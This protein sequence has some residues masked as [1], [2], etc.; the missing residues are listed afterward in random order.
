MKKGSKKKE[1]ADFFSS[2]TAY[3]DSIYTQNSGD[4][5]IFDHITVTGRQHYLLRFLLDHKV[6]GIA[7]DI[8]CG[9]GVLMK[10][11]EKQQVQTVGLDISPA[12]ARKTKEVM[13]DVP[14]FLGVVQGDIEHLPFKPRAFAAVTSIGVLQYLKDDKEAIA[15]MCRVTATEG[16]VVCSTPNLLRLNNFFDPYY[17]TRRGMDYCRYVVNKKILKKQD[18][19][20]ASEYHDNRNFGNRRYLRGQLDKH[21]LEHRFKKTNMAGVGYGPFTLWKN[22]VLPDSINVMLNDRMHR[23]SQ[24]AFGKWMGF[25]ATR[26]VSCYKNEN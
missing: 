24:K 6:K 7:L 5:D 14:G 2:A 26:W 25:L 18:L 8:G 17:Y 19:F 11:L 21:F 20:S 23:F 4:V 3:W 12:M 16:V 22:K 15:E 10:Q 13:S 9:A 1:V